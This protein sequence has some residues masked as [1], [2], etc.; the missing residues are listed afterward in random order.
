MPDTPPTAAASASSSAPPL[1]AR[2]LRRLAEAADGRRGEAYAIFYD[3]TDYVVAPADAT[4]KGTKLVDLET[5]HLARGRKVP[6]NLV[7]VQ[8][9]GASPRPLSSEYD[10]MFWS[11]AAV[12][13]FVLPYYQRLLSRPAMNDLLDAHEDPNVVGILHIRPSVYSPLRPADEL[14]V[15]SLSPTLAP[16]F[17]PLTAWA[18]GR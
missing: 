15:A 8:M 14:R 1:S 4:D 13:K 5:P 17:L 2:A 7:H 16:D 10:A 9:P 18:R 6:K 3:G 12:E 11:E